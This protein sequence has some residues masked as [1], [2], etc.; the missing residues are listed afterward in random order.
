M[1]RGGSRKGEHRGN[2]KARP[3]G[4]TTPNGIMRAAVAAPARTP[5]KRGRPDVFTTPAIIEEDVFMSQVIHGVRSAD[6][7]TPKQVMLDN[8]HHFQNAAYQYEA[9]VKMMARQPDSEETRRA[10]LAYE[11][12]VERHRRIASDE[13]YKVA[14]F[15]HPRLAAIAVRGD[16]GHGDDIVQIMLDEIDKKNREHPIVIEHLPQKKTA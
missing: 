14:P 10:I 2:A 16:L 7:M 13:A 6:D 15:I 9:M 3:E 4:A 5:G 8:M 1:P 11:A 12:E